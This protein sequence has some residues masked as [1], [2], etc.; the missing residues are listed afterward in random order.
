MYVLAAD[1][2]DLIGHDADRRLQRSDDLCAAMCPDITGDIDVTEP[3]ATSQDGKGPDQEFRSGREV[4]LS[5]TQ[6]KVE[7]TPAA[8]TSSAWGSHLLTRGADHEIRYTHAAM[9]PS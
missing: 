8:E 9:G 2:E 7:R 5:L 6:I 4:T 3:A 1:P